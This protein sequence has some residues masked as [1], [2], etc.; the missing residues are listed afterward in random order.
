MSFIF[1]LKS[2]TMK[3]LKIILFLSLLSNLA[4]GQSG[5]PKEIANIRKIYNE[6]KQLIPD[7]DK[8]TSS[9]EGKVLVEGLSVDNKSSYTA[10]FAKNRG[11][12]NQRIIFIESR[13]KGGIDGLDSATEYL[14]DK[15]NLIFVYQKTSAEGNS[16][17]IRCYYQDKKIIARKGEYATSEECSGLRKK[18][19]E[20]KKS[21]L[22]MQM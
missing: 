3:S 8:L 12:D 1:F 4:F 20:L 9:Y 13:F 10:Y 5:E 2:A 18:G 6:T 17:E 16:Y 11:L 15:G 19:E 14:F 22:I 21:I 7:R